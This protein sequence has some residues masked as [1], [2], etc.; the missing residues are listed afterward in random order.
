MRIVSSYLI[1]T[2]SCIAG[3][4][5]ATQRPL[6]QDVRQ[7]PA[8]LAAL[9][10]E[11]HCGPVKGF[12]DRPGMIEPPYLYGYVPGPKENSA[13]FWCSKGEDGPFLLVAMRDG[14]IHSYLTWWGDPMGL[15]LDTLEHRDLSTFSYVDG[16]E[17]GLRGE[18]TQHRAIVS[19][20][21]GVVVLFYEYEG[22]WL[23]RVF[24]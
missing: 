7:L 1:L 15:S 21:G 17:S 24:H 23:E 18:Y 13:V 12:F 19:R 20:Y 22:R 11:L 14:A 2:L 16:G 4:H 6:Q 3:T 10:S 9:A 5:V 8:E